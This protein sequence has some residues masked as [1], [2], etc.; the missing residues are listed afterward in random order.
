MR[1][2]RDDMSFGAHADAG[3]AV[4]D[5][6]ED[7]EAR[8]IDIGVEEPDAESFASQ[9]EGQVDGDGALAYASLACADSYYMSH[10]GESDLA[11]P[12]I[13]FAARER[14]VPPLGPSDDHLDVS[15]AQRPQARLDSR[16]ELRQLFQPGDLHREVDRD[17]AAADVDAPNDRVRQTIRV[18]TLAQDFAQ[19][20]EDGIGG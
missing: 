8:P 4:L 18:E 16:L 15:R 19:R 14:D 20:Y 7:R 13:A 3:G 12:W 10:R 17:A 11:I 9:R 5:P 1:L 6:E 2:E